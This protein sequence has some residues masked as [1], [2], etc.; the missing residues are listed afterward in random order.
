MGVNMDR[1]L[2]SNHKKFK[3]Q[4]KK[5][6]YRQF[7]Y[8]KKKKKEEKETAMEA[9]SNYLK[10]P[11]DILAGAPIITATGKNELV[12]ENYKN[13]IEYTGT[14][15]RVQTKMGRICIEGVNLN[16]NYFNNDEM[17]VTGIIRTIHYK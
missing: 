2:K 9:V 12:V 7:E 14:I 6:I 3:K 15:I 8:S 4:S 1:S 16:I 10:L 17:K 13:I 11:A 5:T